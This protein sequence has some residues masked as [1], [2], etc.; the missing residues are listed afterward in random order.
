MPS[1]GLGDDEAPAAGASFGTVR[2]SAP[3]AK[4]ADLQSALAPLDADAFGAKIYENVGLNDFTPTQ[5]NR[6][7]DLLALRGYFMS[8]LGPRYLWIVK[9]SVIEWP[10]LSAQEKQLHA[11]MRKSFVTSYTFGAEAILQHWLWK[12]L[13]NATK[14]FGPLLKVF[15]TDNDATSSCG[16]DAWKSIFTL[17]PRAGTAITHQLIVTGFEHCM[18]I[19]DDSTAAFTKYIARLNESWPN[20]FDDEI[21]LSI[22]F[23][24]GFNI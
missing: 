6:V 3:P 20:L 1:G 23:L 5:V 16:T 22:G 9:L 2:H 8:Q 19:P 17:F 4:P 21:Y 15:A 14:S 24:I 18:S 13:K 7:G 12:T 10:T 11:A